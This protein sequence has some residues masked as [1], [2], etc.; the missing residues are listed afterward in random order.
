MAKKPDW[1]AYSRQILDGLD[2]RAE[3]IALGVNVSTAG[4][5]STSGWLPAHAYGREDRTPSASINVGDGP[6]RGRYKDFGG[7][8]ESLGL[9]D[10]AGQH[11]PYADWKEAR[12][13]YAKVAGV[14]LPKGCKPAK[15]P[16]ESI[17]WRGMKPALVE[18][19][20]QK[21][22]GITAAAA[23]L[24]GVRLGMWPEPSSKYPIVAFP[25]Y[26][27]NLLDADPCAWVIMARNGRPLPLFKGKNIPPEPRKILT[28]GGGKAGWIGRHALEHLEE[29]E[30]IWK[31]EGVTTLLALQGIIP[32]DKR[33]KHLVLTN[34]GGAMEL[35]RPE[36][37][38]C[39]VGK[40][41]YVVGDADEPGA[42]GATRWAKALGGVAIEVRNVLSPYEIVEDHGKDLRDWII[43]QG[44]EAYEQLLELAHASPVYRPYLTPGASTPAESQTEPDELATYYEKKI[45]KLL[46]IDVLGELHGNPVVFSGFHRKEVEIQRAA[47]L[48]IDNLLQICGPPAKACLHKGKDDQRENDL[49]KVEDA[50][51]AIMLLAGYKRLDEGGITGIGCWTATDEEGVETGQV[52]LVN[53]GEASR[54][55]AEASELVHLLHPRDGGRILS[56]SSSTP[57]Y[58][59]E[60]LSGYL[61]NYSAEWAMDVLI[62]AVNVFKRW[63]WRSQATDPQTIVGLILA[64]WTQTLWA[65][66]PEVGVAGRTNSGKSLLFA[67]IEAI[68]G[69]MGVLSSKSTAAGMRQVIGTSARVPMIDEF[70]SSKQRQL[71]LEMARA[72]T[73]GDKTYHGTPGQ[74][75]IGSLMQHIFW[76][77]A[78]ELGL[79]KATDQ[80]RFIMFELLPA[81][82]GKHGQLTPPTSVEAFELG[83]KL[84]AIAVHSIGRARELAVELKRTKHE[85]IDF[86]VVESYAV[87]A[88][89]LSVA[90]D[91]E[92]GAEEVLGELLAPLSRDEQRI[93]DEDDLMQ[94][95][96][97][98]VVRMKDGSNQ[99]VAQLL[100]ERGETG[101][102]AREALGRVGVAFAFGRRGPR[103]GDDA[104]Y[105]FFDHKTIKAVILKHTEWEYQSIDQILKRIEGASSSQ[106]S[107]ASRYARGVLIPWEHIDQ[108]FLR[109][110]NAEIGF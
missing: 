78:V 29:A 15:A 79:S 19:W 67:T 2:I 101:T 18:L 32:E 26:G 23:H 106:R 6:G 43:E 64:S 80:N 41:V 76:F 33:D 35:P 83:Q 54:W 12:R 48:S 1:E 57:W 72:A 44:S 38:E 7:G 89:I 94:A 86:R 87:P 9:F 56:I 28:A 55:N 39:L 5:A 99:T 90:T 102:D 31:V 3:Y 84:L 40:R 34:S 60:T 104:P 27:P 4:H 42:E 11:G 69:A 30:V 46:E 36:M 62:E 105:V 65:W 17:A 81:E 50:R 66:R 75:V 22:E 103:G 49:Y 107:V 45:C 21:K 93:S 98:H 95:I 53:A 100:C 24:A 108:H 16:D 82:Q 91:R 68:F 70:E 63:R 73:R 77:A 92:A 110:D 88:A 8:G 59:H 25:A 61:T 74:R 14:K 10:F 20:A 85:G 71:I 37:I 47:K 13:H 109:R 51:A 97:R 96:L 58:S 52:L